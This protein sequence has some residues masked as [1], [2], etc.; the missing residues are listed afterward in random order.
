MSE[1]LNSHD[2]FGRLFEEFRY[3]FWRFISNVKFPELLLDDLDH[4]EIKAADTSDFGKIV[5]DITPSTSEQAVFVMPNH[6]RWSAIAKLAIPY[7]LSTRSVD[8]VEIREPRTPTQR[9]LEYVSF[10]HSDL[11]VAEG[12]LR[13]KDI[14]VERVNDIR[15]DWHCLSVPIYESGKEIRITKNKLI[16][17]LEEDIQNGTAIISRIDN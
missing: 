6:V 11:S 7:A 16:S 17:R 9:K 3:D 10:Y 14:D 4:V 15:H 5:R 1:V 13:S 2:D 12:M 8:L